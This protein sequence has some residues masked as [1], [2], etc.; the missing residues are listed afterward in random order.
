[1]AKIDIPHLVIKKKR[2][3]YWQPSATLKRAGWNSVALGTDP[4]QAQAAA[5]A[6]N[7]KVEEWRTGGLK[8][9][10]V[11]KFIAAGTVS[12]LIRRFKDEHY[13]TG[14]PNNEGIAAN[15]QK[16]YNSKLAI[17]D[18][19]AGKEQVTHITPARLEKLK[20]ALLAADKDGKIHRHRASGTLRVA[21][22]FFAFGEKVGAIPPG[23]NP[24]ARVVIPEPKG[25]KRLWSLDEEGAMRAAAI[26]LGLPSMAL[27]VDLALYT[28]QRQQDLIVF[29]EHQLAE[30]QLF[31]QRLV[32]AFAGKDGVVRGWD[33]SQLK[34]STDMQIPFEPT[35]LE[36]VQATLKRNR[37]CDRPAKRLVSYVLVDDRTGLPFTSH[38]FIRAWQ[39]VLEHAIE[40]TGDQAMKDLQWRDWR[41][42]RVVRLRRRG[43]TRE[44]ISSITGHSLKS[45]DKMLEVYGPI[46]ATITA[47]TLA[48]ALAIDAAEKGK[49][50]ANARA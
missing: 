46:D 30:L 40:K 24:M 35:I 23:S 48:A 10:T 20:A 36:R 11:K 29:T 5:Q 22:T 19:W 32:D 45:I 27:A 4:R 25:R 6:M 15:T 34:T 18:R 42:T 21:R 47:N 7:D 14:G 41:R 17:L 49:D 28:A 50:E 43:F 12:Q 3:Y 37:A 8:P 16:E 26:D 13:A 33:M 38:G 39:E 1:M 44:Q 9:R 2:L 31:D